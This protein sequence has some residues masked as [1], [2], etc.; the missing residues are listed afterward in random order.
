MVLCDPTM[1]CVFITYYPC[2]LF[3]KKKKKKEEEKNSHWWI[4]FTK[5]NE[6]NIRKNKTPVTNEEIDCIRI[7][8]RTFGKRAHNWQRGLETQTTTRGWG[9]RIISIV[10]A[11]RR[12]H[13]TE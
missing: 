8:F 4:F 11:H 5:Q 7:F 12:K 3:D 9:R 6:S 2:Y 10:P 1:F 13:C